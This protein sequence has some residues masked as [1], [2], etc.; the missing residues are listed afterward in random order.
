MELPTALSTDP[1]WPAD[2]DALRTQIAE[3]ETRR[4]HQLTWW[5]LGITPA[6]ILPVLAAL[7]FDNFLLAIIF[8]VMA[9]GIQTV[10]WRRAANRVD[11]LEQELQD[12]LASAPSTG[13]LEEA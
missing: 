5:L 6:S 1:P 8:V 9:A 11:A 13:P 7:W 4:S 12:A 2:I 10:R 3:A